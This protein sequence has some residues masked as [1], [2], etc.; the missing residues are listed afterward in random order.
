MAAAESPIT[1]SVAFLPA[2]SC[3]AGLWKLREGWKRLP[4]RSELC[5]DV[6]WVRAVPAGGG[7]VGYALPN[8]LFK[9][10]RL[11][12]SP[13]SGMHAAPPVAL[14]E[15]HLLWLL[16]SSRGHMPCPGWLD[17]T[18]TPAT[19][20]AVGPWVLTDT[21]D[22]PLGLQGPSRLPS[23]LGHIGATQVSAG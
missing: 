5:G 22:S 21:G 9:K 14:F 15:S 8:L 18:P 3:L 20:V 2:S 4:D 17:S 10:A 23:K 13:S 16:F 7:E 1:C 6:T 12:K 19:E 11:L